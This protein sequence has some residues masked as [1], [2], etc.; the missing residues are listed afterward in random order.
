MDFPNPI[1]NHLLDDPLHLGISGIVNITCDREAGINP[2]PFLFP[3]YTLSCPPW[4]RVLL[5]GPPLNLRDQM[6]FNAM[7]EMTPLTRCHALLKFRESENQ[8]RSDQIRPNPKP[9][10]RRNPYQLVPCQSGI[11]AQSTLARPVCRQNS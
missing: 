6:S 1:R 7:P 4:D 5:S 10:R 9:R 2:R 8:I 11:P 3:S